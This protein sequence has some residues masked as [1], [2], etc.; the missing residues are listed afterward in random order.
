MSFSHWTPD[1]LRR[2]IHAAGVALWSWNV[3]ED[4]LAMDEQGFALWAVEATGALTFED[5]SA[6]I[7]P[8]DRDGVRAAFAATRGVEGDCETDFRIMVLK[9]PRRRGGAPPRHICTSK[10]WLATLGRQGVPT[11]L[12]PGRAGPARDQQ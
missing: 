2:A 5:L 10:R 12:V 3:A 6:R 8:A 7:H 11:I 1:S 9:G 4:G